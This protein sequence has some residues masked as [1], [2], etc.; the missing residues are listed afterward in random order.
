MR[1]IGHDVESF[2]NYFCVGIEDYSTNSKILFEISEERNDVHKIYSYYSTYD[3][4]IVSFNGI[5]Y[6]SPMI[7]Y[8]LLNYS[9]FKDLNVASLTARMKMFSDK[10]IE[11]DNQDDVRKIRYIKDKWTEIDLFLYWSRGVRLSWKISLKSLGIQLGYPVV[12]ELPYPPHHYLEVDELPVIREYNMTHDL[13]VLRLLYD[14]MKEDVDLRGYIRDTLG[15]QCMSM[16]APK[17][18]SQVLLKEYCKV[19]RLNAY[20][21]EKWRFERTPIHIESVLRGFNPHFETKIFQDMFQKWKDSYDTISESLVFSLNNTDLSLTYGIGGLHSV[22][23]N[24]IY[25][26]TDT[27]IVKTSDVRSMYPNLIINYRCIRF[28]EVLTK[29]ETVKD[30]RAVAKKNKEKA[31]DSLFKLILNSTSGLLD[32][33]VSWLYFP[34]G[35]LRM[36]L[37]GQLI[38]TKHIEVCAL[39]GWK[40]VSANT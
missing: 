30:D 21:V 31:K 25:T 34:E 10:I 11:D 7:K 2:H 35:A 33:D 8:L 32:S 22:N 39:R 37:I 19:K 26:T 29:Y 20:N 13:G 5:H 15:I 17:I 36:R 23:K 27:H 9:T 4:D 16:D 3:G 18:A 28:P 14:K 38:L 40:V 1:R 24:E 12:Q 6:D